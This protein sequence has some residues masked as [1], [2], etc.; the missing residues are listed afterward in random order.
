MPQIFQNVDDA[1]SEQHNAIL[2]LSLEPGQDPIKTV[3]ADTECPKAF[4]KSGSLN[5]LL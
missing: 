2:Y 5:D 4:L 1:T 3:T